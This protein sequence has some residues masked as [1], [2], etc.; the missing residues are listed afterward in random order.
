MNDT[1]R[2]L[3][4]HRTTR[5]FKPNTTIPQQ[6]LQE[7]LNAAR[8]AA[9]WMNAQCYSIIVT[10]ND[11]IKSTLATLSAR[12][13]HIKT[14]AVFLIFCMDFTTQKIAC[15]YH[16][17]SFYLQDNPDFLMVGA[18]DATLAMQ[19]A[20]I[21]SE[22][23]GYGTVCV[24]GIRNIA[25][26]V[27]KLFNLPEF[28]YPV[29]GLSIGVIDDTISV[30]N[31]K[32]RFDASVK[33][34]YDSY[35]VPTQDDVLLYNDTMTQFAEARETKLWSEKFA[36]YFDNPLNLVTKQILQEQNFIQ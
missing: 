26:D 36:D 23:L 28:V 17:K 16:H 19:N 4:N 30:E 25:R 3:Q 27:I 10:E 15:D 32:P 21:A 31:I 13:P 11:E 34:H 12:N 20:I 5:H 33:V 18:M 14:S 7:I 2:L 22:S 24:G 1:I 9:S 35:T 29:C 6:H 8:Q